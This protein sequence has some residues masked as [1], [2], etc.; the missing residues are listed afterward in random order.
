MFDLI[1]TLFSYAIGVMFFAFIGSVI[2]FALQICIAPFAFIGI[3]IIDLI[4]AIKGK[5]NGN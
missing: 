5:S 3:L 4:E 1:F 2:I